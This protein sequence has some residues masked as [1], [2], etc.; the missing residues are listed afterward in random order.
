MSASGTIRR[1]G[2]V[3]V[4]A[5]AL[6]GCGLPGAVVGMHA[7]PRETTT[8]ASL[9]VRSAQRITA[10]VL[11]AARAAR[12]QTGRSAKADQEAVLTGAALA[13][14]EAATAT[15][16]ATSPT[17]AP[18]TKPGTPTVLSVSQGRI[19]PRAIL[20]T[21]FD[22]DTEKQSLYVLVSTSADAP[23][24]L[25]ATVTMHGGSKIPALGELA[26]GAPLVPADDGAGMVASPADVL[27][28]YAGALGYPK[29]A[30]APAVSAQDA[31]A[32]TLRA[33][34]TAQAST[35]GKLGTL[36]QEQAVVTDDTVT[37]RLAGGGAVVFGMLRRT[38]RIALAKSAKE[39]VLPATYAALS[40]KKKVTTGVRILSLEPV[41]LVV[42]VSGT[43][44]GIAADQQIVSVTGH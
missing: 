24:K 39:L 31:F 22:E 18:L 41:A 7:A 9:D 34:A 37:F 3:L 5:L 21:T 32:Q 4:A 38:D 29:A 16:S 17:P 14:A 19:W 13:V 8:A 30:R 15:H 6:G 10:R 11:D 12:A 28:Q 42:P 40:G 43:A 35:L 26:D 25:A 23:F 33:S 20:A 44:T 2:A 36:T 1:A 27:R